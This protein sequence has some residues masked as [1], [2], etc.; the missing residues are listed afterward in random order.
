MTRRPR[1]TIARLK[2]R[3]RLRPSAENRRWRLAQQFDMHPN[4]IQQ[5]K[6]QLLAGMMDVFDGGVKKAAA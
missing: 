4:Q 2:P 3:C 1:Q 6:E 5:W